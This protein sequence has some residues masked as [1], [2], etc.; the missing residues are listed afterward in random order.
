MGVYDRLISLEDK[1]NSIR[2]STPTIV[3]FIADTTS[4]DKKKINEMVYTTITDV[5]NNVP[6]CQCGQKKGKFR[7]GEYCTNCHSKVTEV[8]EEYLE[9]K[10]WIQRPVGVSKLVSPQIWK[11]LRDKFKLG[12]SNVFD[13]ICYITDSK[14]KEP[15]DNVKPQK[16]FKFIQEFKDRGF[17]RSYNYFIDNLDEI[18][19]FLFTSKTLDKKSGNDLYRLIMENKNIILT[20]HVPLPNKSVLVLEESP[21]HKFPDPGLAH[22]VSAVRHVSGIDLPGRVLTSIQRQNRVS[23][24]LTDLSNYYGETYQK[25]FTPKEGLFRKHVF[26]TRVDYSFRT[27]IS[28]LTDKHRY[29]EIHVSWSACINVLYNH[30]LN[31]LFRLGYSPN[32]AFEFINSVNLEYNAEMERIINELIS[33]AGPDGIC[34]L[35]NRNPSLGRGSIQ[36]VYITKIKTDVRDITTSISI[37]ICPAMNADFDGDSINFMLA[38]DKK[39]EHRARLLAPETNIFDL[40]SIHGVSDVVSIP[41]PVAGTFASWLDSPDMVNPDILSRMKALEV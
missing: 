11:M 31:K 36:R 38:L 21:Y 27:V 39:S 20:D 7:L 19:E 23:K 34:C 22:A 2:G 24:C 41:K 14:Y 9:N 25:V 3:N 5:F 6:T 12:N 15:P 26:G 17:K 10:I 13:T 18:L 33:E 35:V 8:I 37:L 40:H 4:D 30:I 28:S 1:F 29:D 16:A 32:E